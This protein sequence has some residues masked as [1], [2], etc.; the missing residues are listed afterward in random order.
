[1][2][3]LKTPA[4]FRKNSCWMSKNTRMNGCAIVNKECLDDVDNDKEEDIKIEIENEHTEEERNKR[5]QR[6]N[7]YRPEQAD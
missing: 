6:R 7:R 1:M 2:S 5:E 4:F 3:T